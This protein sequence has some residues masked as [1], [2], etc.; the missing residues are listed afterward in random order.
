MEK[1]LKPLN[2]PTEV[3]EIL[4]D[5]CKNRSIKINMGDFAGEAIREKI[6]REKD[7]EGE[8]IK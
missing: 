4:V 8:K 2:I 7:R 6:A 5:H 1:K 3:H